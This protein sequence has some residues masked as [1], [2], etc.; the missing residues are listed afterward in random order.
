CPRL[1]KG[2]VVVMDNLKIHKSVKVQ[3]MIT[4]KGAK[5]LYVPRCSPNFNPI[6]M[7]WSILK[8]FIRYSHFK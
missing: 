3:Q 7:L 4:D 6:E 5:L 8:G 2:K 1:Y